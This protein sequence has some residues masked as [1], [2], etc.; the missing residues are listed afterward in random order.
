SCRGQASLRASGN[1][2]KVLRR[3][4]QLEGSRL[5]WRTLVQCTWFGTPTCR[6]HPEAPTSAPSLCPLTPNRKTA[7][8][9]PKL[10]AP[11]ICKESASVLA[12]QSVHGFS[13][14]PAPAPQTLFVRSVSTSRLS[15]SSSIRASVLPVIV[16]FRT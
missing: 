7:W 2:R 6:L 1:R 9:N 5:V 4:P 11:T 13:A 16:Y 8:P 12:L 3:K 10:C 14:G 15:G